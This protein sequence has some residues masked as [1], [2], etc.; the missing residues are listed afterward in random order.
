MP[1]QP[2]A[3]LEL[4]ERW[5]MDFV[6]P[7]HPPSNQKVSILVCTDYMTKW[8]EAKAL[9]RESKEVVL[10]FLF[11]NIFVR[12]GVPRELVTDGG[13]PFTSHKFEALLSKYHVLHRIASPYHPQGNGQV[14]GP[15]KV[16][17]AILTKTVREN[18][19]DWSNRLHESL[20]AYRTTWRSTTSFSP[21]ELVYGKSPIFP[22]EFE[23]KTLITTST[24]NLDLTMEQ[25]ARLQQLNEVDEKRLDAIHQTT[26]IQQQRTKWHE[27]IIKKKLF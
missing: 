19:K 12:F 1:L 21:Y 18:R 15:N 7:I 16:I 5:A 14:E 3:V 13:P 22:I 4:F 23:I 9:I 2:Q 10:A 26:M 17:E 20:W 25:K 11:E 24:V 27:R 8:V 6:G